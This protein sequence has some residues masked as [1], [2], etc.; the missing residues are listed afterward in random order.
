MSDETSSEAGGTPWLDQAIERCLWRLR[1]EGEAVGQKDDLFLLAAPQHAAYPALIVRDPC[2]TATDVRVY[3]YLRQ[4]IEAGGVDSLVWRGYRQAMAELDLSRATFA[5]SLARLR[6]SRWMAL[7]RQARRKDGRWLGNIYILFDEPQD[8]EVILRYDTGFLEW[9]RLVLYGHRDR[10]A[11]RLAA[12]I[13]AGVL[14]NLDKHPD[15]PL[16]YDGDPLERRLESTEAIARREGNRFGIPMVD[17]A[18]L[19]KE[20]GQDGENSS[21]APR[22]RKQPPCRGAGSA[23]D[24]MLQGSEFGLQESRQRGDRSAITVNESQKSSLDNAANSKHGSCQLC[25]RS[26]ITLGQRAESKSLNEESV[27]YD[28]SSKFELGPIGSSSS[29]S[30]R[31]TTTTT[32][33]SPPDPERSAIRARARGGGRVRDPL[34]GLRWPSG[35]SPQDRFLVGQVLLTVGEEHRQPV[36]DALRVRL[37]AVKRGADPLRYPPHRYVRALCERVR[38]GTF[39]PVDGVVPVAFEAGMGKQAAGGGGGREDALRELRSRIASL[40]QLIAGTPSEELRLLLGQQLREAKAELE[41]LRGDG[42]G[43]GE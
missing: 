37:D 20:L 43:D 4:R 24:E 18:S 16:A 19:E 14:R 2:V 3:L 23:L 35:L 11:R 39:E 13:V 9:I 30:Y 42:R 1:K 34:A 26:A 17:W 5:S 12:E 21:C 31:T 41:T 22:R 25:D 28:P 7:C 6:L 36:L 33:T 10:L 8:V 29:R 38:E 32:T 27:T 40:E 15:R